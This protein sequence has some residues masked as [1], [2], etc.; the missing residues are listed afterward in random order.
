MNASRDAGSGHEGRAL[1]QKIADILWEAADLLAQQKANPFRVSAYRR[2]A[3]SLQE[4]ERPAAEILEKEGVEGLIALP[5]IGEGIAGAIEEILQRG[6]W[7]LLER[8]RG[9]LDPVKLFQTVPGIGPKLARRIH[10]TLQLDTLEALEAAA[11]DG[12]L[13]KVPGL[14]PE[15][16]LT[17]RAVLLERLGRV[18]LRRKRSSLQEIPE[19]R[20][21]LDVDRE[22]REKAEAGRLPTITPRRFNP[23]AEKWL[24]ILHTERDRWHFTLLFSN[25][26]RAHELNKI[27]DWVVIYFDFENQEGQCTVVTESRGPLAGRRVVRGRETECLEFYRRSGDDST[28]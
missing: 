15:R 20:V 13:Q 11:H 8:L 28:S 6:Q 14:G 5:S 19:V 21:L 16:C 17:I 7:S 24:P 9:T 1:N 4:L 2:G 10:D 26:A 18:R 27:R 25:T 3:R 22:Y 23:G 12:R